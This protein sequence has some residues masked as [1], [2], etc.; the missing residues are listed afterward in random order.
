MSE[1]AGT[2]G[3]GQPAR[4]VRTSADSVFALAQGFYTAA[5]PDKAAPGG[6]AHNGTFALVDD[7]GHV[8]GLYD[9]L[10][11]QEVARLQQ[12]LPMLLA[13]VKQRQGAK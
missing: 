8:R 4:R 3:R 6:F 2:T 12:E 13:E 10:N 5:M 9:S 7:Q 11:P 1:R